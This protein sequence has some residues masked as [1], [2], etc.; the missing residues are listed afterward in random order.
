M[1]DHSAGAVMEAMEYPE[2]YG[3]DIQIFFGFS[4][5]SANM[6]MTDGKS[7]ENVG[8]TPDEMTTPLHRT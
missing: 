5:T 1:G 7:L 4:I 3:A 2:S 8:V 6:V